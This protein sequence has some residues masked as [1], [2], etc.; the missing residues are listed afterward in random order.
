MN[1]AKA[2]ALMRHGTA[3]AYLQNVIS[4]CTPDQGQLCFQ[5]TIVVG[6]YRAAVPVY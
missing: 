5:T 4:P 1:R 2:E 6:E 3:C